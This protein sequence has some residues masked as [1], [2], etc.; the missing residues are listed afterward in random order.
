MKI[1]EG[2]KSTLTSIGKGFLIF[3]WGI[4]PKCL[5][6][7]N[8]IKMLKQGFFVK[9]EMRSLPPP[10]TIFNLQKHPLFFRFKHEKVCCLD[11]GLKLS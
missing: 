5:M 3:S 6:E 4:L 8:I 2:V 9:V 1:L 7:P 10:E 11:S